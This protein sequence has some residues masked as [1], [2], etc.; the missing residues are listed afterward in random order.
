MRPSARQTPLSL[1]ISL[2]V[3]VIAWFAL[4]PTQLGGAITYIIVDGNSMEPKFHYGDLVLVREQRV[5]QVGEAVT[6]QNAEMGRLVFHRIVAIQSDRFVLQG[7]NNAWLDGYQPNQGEIIGKLWVH[8]P[9]VGKAIQWVRQPLYL[10][11]GFGTLGGIMAAG[12]ILSPSQ[13]GKRK[14][15]YSLPTGGFGGFLEGGLYVTGLAVLLFLGLTLF[16]FTR[17]LT[18]PAENLT[19]QQDNY[20]VYSA[21]GTPGVY[22]SNTIQ[23]GEPIFPKLTCFLNVSSVYNLTGNGSQSVSGKQQFFGRVLDEKSGWQRTF[24]LKAETSFTG[25]S[26][27]SQAGIDLCQVQALVA[28]M[29][30]QTGLRTTTYTFEVNT[31]TSVT[32]ILAGTPMTDALDATL[33]FKFDE[34]HFYLDTASKQNSPLQTTK[35]GTI[36]T[37]DQSP[38]SLSVLGMAVSIPATRVLSLL[39]LAVSLCGAMLLGWSFLNNA[40]ANPAEMIRL[41]YRGL[42]MDVHGLN[43]QPNQPVV[44]VASVDDLARLAE[45]QNAMIAHLAINSSH[46]YFVQSNGTLYRH[47]PGAVQNN[48]PALEQTLARF[49][50]PEQGQNNYFEAIPV[51][52]EAY[53]YQVD[54]NQNPPI[55][56][57]TVFMGRVKL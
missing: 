44:D 49:S 32:G 4:A 20:F 8:I 50:L 36:V 16:T 47:V 17:P 9:K 25:N 13:S 35:T 29:E 43:V 54:L 27:A 38:N 24:P 26:H 42:V 55:P 40:Q 3:A 11:L 41:K 48:V 14:G 7:D 45:R 28:Q 31:H 19:Y 46:Q 18:R 37:S 34:V 57:Q 5:Y 51:D 10:A 6:Y 2:A 33:R 23:P 53:G 22:D 56:T 30:Q 1:L 12:L 21:T 52:H 39:G 15:K